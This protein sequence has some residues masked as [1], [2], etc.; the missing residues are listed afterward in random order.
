MTG[1][2]FPK[3]NIEFE[4]KLPEAAFNRLTKIDDKIYG[5]WTASAHFG[6]SVP[7]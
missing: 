6:C 2:D 4:E 3:T 7:C 5:V 1:K